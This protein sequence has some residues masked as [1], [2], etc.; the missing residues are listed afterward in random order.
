ML[1]AVHPWGRS[2]RP[3]C[4]RNVV[5]QLASE[6]WQVAG[7]YRLREEIFCGEQGIFPASDRDRHDAFGLPI[8]ALCQIAGVDQEVVGVVRIYPV[9]E[10]TWYG[11]RLGVRKS[12]RRVGAIGTALITCAVSTAHARGCHKFL[13]TVQ[14]QNVKYFER[15]DFARVEEIEVEGRAHW[16]MEARLDSYPKELST[17]PIWATQTGR[18]QAA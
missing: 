11:G 5:A 1:D 17:S 2:I 6:P 15:H 12:H 4:P 16:L 3:F 8:V 18:S 13:A 10:Q 9:G 14:P 7:H